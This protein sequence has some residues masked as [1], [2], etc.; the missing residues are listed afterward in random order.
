MISSSWSSEFLSSTNLLVDLELNLLLLFIVLAYSLTPIYTSLLLMYR[1]DSSE[2]H[3]S[4][5]ESICYCSM[6]D[7]FYIFMGIIN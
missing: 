1:F 3:C 5:T 7:S 4:L 6:S 2:E